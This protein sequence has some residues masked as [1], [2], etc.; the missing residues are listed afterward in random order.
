ML[1]GQFGGWS[2]LVGGVGWELFDQA[3]LRKHVD[4]MVEEIKE[5]AT[6]E[7]KL[8][9]VGRYPMV[10]DAESVSGILASTVG[11]ATELDR[12]LGYEAN[13]TGTS[14]LN[15]PDEMIGVHKIGSPLLS[16][17]GNRNE[18]G[19]IATVKWDD[20]GVSPGSFDLVRDGVLQRFQTTR[21]S[22]QW[23]RS[24]SGTLGAEVKS[25]GCSHAANGVEAPL[26]RS[27]N[28]T[29]VPADNS[30]TISDL[31]HD[32]KRG[33]MFKGLQSDM[34]FQQCD[35]LGTGRC[36]EITNGKVSAVLE[37]AG[38]LFKAP[39]LWKSLMALGGKDTLQ[40]YGSVSPKGQPAQRAANSVSAVPALFENGTIIDFM[41]KA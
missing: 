13:A 14:Y 22:A 32:V 39:E 38:V 6:L 7:R 5:D 31:Y 30:T 3:E 29:M 16:V 11:L 1:P 10:L 20:D 2:R 33:V 9:D 17:N 23:I 36:Y 37:S 15:L 21:E 40:R 4:V 26:T 41:R 35:G 28:L 25:S 12:A 24:S 34:D 18:P 8:V 19:G 27:A